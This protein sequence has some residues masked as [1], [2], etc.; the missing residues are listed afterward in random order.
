MLTSIKEEDIK[1]NDNI[2]NIEVSNNVELDKINDIKP[3]L[4]AFLRRMGYLGLEVKGV[5]DE[6]KKNEASLLIKQSDYKASDV[7]LEKK[8]STLIFG[9]EIKGKTFELKNIIAE[10]NDVTIEVFVLV[11]NL[12]KQLKGLI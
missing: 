7:N 11:W 3:K 6:E 4:T 1:I 5:L 8:E 10:M 9:N 2:I 12:K